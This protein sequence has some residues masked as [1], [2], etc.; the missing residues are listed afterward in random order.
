MMVVE[1]KSRYYWLVPSFLVV[2][3]VLLITQ[4][5]KPVG[6]GVS[7]NMVSGIVDSTLLHGYSLK[8]FV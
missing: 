7:H 5:L 4:L 1:I 2:L 3:M 8:L 6:V